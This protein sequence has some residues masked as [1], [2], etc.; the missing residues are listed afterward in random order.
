M[1]NVLV[2]GDGGHLGHGGTRSFEKGE[3]LVWEM[4]LSAPDGLELVADR[5][6][7]RFVRFGYNTI[8]VHHHDG[9]WAKAF[10]ARHPSLPRLHRRSRGRPHLL[11]NRA[12]TPNQREMGR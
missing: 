1:K 10:A 6:V 3:R 5:L 2:L 11:R 8:C 12:V 9:A 7:D 4:S